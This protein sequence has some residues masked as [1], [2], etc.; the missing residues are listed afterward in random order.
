MTEKAYKSMR[1]VGVANIAIGVVVM[2][3]G[4]AAGIITVVGGT[5]LLK[6]K[7]ELTF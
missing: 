6:N 3:I 1:W 4:I 2:V 5:R 7:N